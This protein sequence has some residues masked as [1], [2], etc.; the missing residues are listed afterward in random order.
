MAQASIL[1]VLIIILITVGIGTVV[2]FW[3]VSTIGRAQLSFSAPLTA[4]LQQVSEDLIIETVIFTQGNITVF[5][6][7]TGSVNLVIDHAYINYELKPLID[8][9]YTEPE[10][11][12]A[13]K[14]K[15][16]EIGA[17]SISYNWESGKTYHLML[18]TR[19]GNT[20]ETYVR[21][22]STSA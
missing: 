14:L 6:K 15:P 17:I 12:Y 3:G 10:D 16:R 2:L 13:L 22:P 9:S 18:A 8:N 11:N 4:N 5:V 19:R 20:F 21:A 7:N 1:G